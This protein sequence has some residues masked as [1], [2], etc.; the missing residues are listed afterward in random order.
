[1]IGGQEETTESEAGANRRICPCFS[2]AEKTARQGEANGCK[3][4]RIIS[5][6]EL[7]AM[8]PNVG[9]IGAMISPNTAIFDPFRY[10]VALAENAVKNG[11]ERVLVLERNS[12]AGGTLNQCIHDG[13]GLVR[14]HETL[15]GP[16]YAHRAAAEAEAAGVMLKTDA[17]VVSMSRDR[18]VSVVSREGFQTYEAGAVVLATGCRERTRGAL[19]IPGSRP[20]GIFTAGVVQNL[21]NAKNVMVGKRVVILGSGDIG[22]IM[23]RRLTLE[24]AKVL[25]VAEVM[26]TSGGLQRNISQCLYDFGIPL[27]TSHTVSN[28]FG[29]KK[30][31]GVEISRVDDNLKPIP[32][33]AWTIDCDA[34]V[35]SVGLIPE[36]EVAKAAGV[37]LDERTN[38]TITDEWMQTSVPGVFSCGNAHAVM[39]LVDFVSAQGECAGKNA[40][41]F[42]KGEAMTPWKLDRKSEPA[43][44]LPEP[45]ALNC[46]L[47]P[48]GCRLRY[49]ADGSVSGNR[50]SRGEE[51][52]LQERT[53]PRRTL[54]L[55]VRTESGR[56]VPVRTERPI[57]REKLLEGAEKLQQVILPDRD[58]ACGQVLVPELMGAAVIACA[59]VK[60]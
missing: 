52:A 56:L 50:C 34:L 44:G 43:K 13:F 2:L 21:V 32:G 40:A 1:M 16:Q 33:T 4:L 14:Y 8:A 19:A 11:A 51:Y 45:D 49:E 53:A 12:C 30:L 6:D 54:T 20:A 26:K 27:Y 22:L 42:L 46:I 17:M 28:I 55:T 57:P 60:I 47:C 59:N 7:A 41:A 58:I 29:K 23:A 24:G 37:A 38:G 36:N 5:K 48:N 18:R 15:T 39:D 10:T 35:L 3:G 25:A 9:G 31:T